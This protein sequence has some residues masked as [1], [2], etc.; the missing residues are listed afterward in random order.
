MKLNRNS[1]L[2]YVSGFEWDSPFFL[3]PRYFFRNTR[4]PRGHHGIEFFVV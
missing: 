4:H 3:E 1:T 2:K